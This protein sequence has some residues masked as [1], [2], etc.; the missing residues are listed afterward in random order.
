[1]KK[2]IYF[3]NAATTTAK[4]E[5]VIRAS[6]AAM[7]R[8]GNP[9]RSGHDI[10]VYAAESVYM[11]RESICRLFGFDK[12]E[13]VVFTANATY[14]LN[15]AI[16]GCAQNN[17]HILI[18]NFEHNSVIRPVH[19]LSLDK[20]RG[21][22]YSFFNAAGT[23]SE[24]VYD[25]LSK[26]KPNT[27]MAVVTFASNVC[28]KIL[29][30]QKIS[31]VCRQRGILLICDA[32]QGAGG[33]PIN[34]KT[35]GADIICF[36]GHKSLYGPQGTG[37]IIFCC[38]NDPE[39][40]IEGGNGVNSA[41]RQMSGNLP[42]KLEAG[43]VNTPGICGL[44]A[45]IGYVSKIGINEIFDRNTFLINRLSENLKNI[46]G[47]TLYGECELRTPTI[48]FNKNRMP[49]E[50][51]AQVLNERKICVRGGFH[52]APA[53]HTALET[54]SGGAVR[55]SLTFTNTLQEIDRFSFELSK[56]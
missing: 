27:K 7:E 23:D 24:I 50:E 31:S 33:V 20:S 47:V 6:A 45:G 13:R 37:G 21:I 25:F 46:D 3:D 30:V 11:C 42:E 56:I 15:I 9:G 39:T 26:I 55:A 28:G 48:V 2:Y 36:A 4:P 51:L 34:T 12:P 17:S 8:L 44:G 14:A 43:T 52:C 38:R 16:K 49:S 54:G 35:L 10:S 18:S 19:K 40:I 1:M 53:A 5:A 41:D 32:S 29:P 22:T